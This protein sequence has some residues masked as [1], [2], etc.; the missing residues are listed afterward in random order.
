[1]S[2]LESIIN[3][4]LVMDTN[5]IMLARAELTQLRADLDAAQK[6]IALNRY[7]TPP[8]D[9]CDEDTVE[10]ALELVEKDR[11]I[12][13][14]EEYITWVDHQ[15]HLANDELITFEKRIA[16][17]ETENAS[18]TAALNRA[19][20]D[21]DYCYVCG[22]HGKHAAECPLAAHPAPQPSAEAC[23]RCEQPMGEGLLCDNCAISTPWPTVDE[24]PPDP[25]EDVS[26]AAYAAFDKW[27][28]EFVS[29]LSTDKLQNLLESFDTVD[30][31][32]LRYAAMKAFEAEEVTP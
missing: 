15:Y 23:P 11:R 2:V 29:H 6:T 13:K 24:M 4:T 30:F 16:S 26:S 3:G 7:V 8:F 5:H 25:P 17:L 20:N 27:Q 9:L 22:N 19:L 1:M 28:S 18:L 31:I 32:D 10:L 21:S 14:R 12:A